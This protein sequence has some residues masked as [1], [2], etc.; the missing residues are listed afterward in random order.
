MNNKLIPLL[1]LGLLFTCSAMAGQPKGKNSN[2]RIYFA[3]LAGD[4]RQMVIETED[5]A[6]T[7]SITLVS[8]RYNK[9]GEVVDSFTIPAK[10]RKIEF[11]D[12][13]FDQQQRIVVHFED[14]DR[15]CYLVI[16]QFKNDRLSKVFS[17]KS[18]YG[19]EANF[20]LFTRIKVGKASAHSNSSVSTPDWDN[21]VWTSDKFI[22]E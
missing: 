10:I 15:V 16:Y 5:K 1:V 22:K 8:V 7:D 17:A 11:K 4:G 21:W 3:N 9:K 13:N 18:A 14:K 19:I 2:I 20:D 12:F 6:A